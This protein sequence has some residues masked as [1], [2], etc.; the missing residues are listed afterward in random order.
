[1]QKSAGLAEAQRTELA[2]HCNALIQAYEGEDPAAMRAAT[3]DVV[4]IVR[5]SFAAESGQAYEVLSLYIIIVAINNFL[6]NSVLEDAAAQE[7]FLSVCLSRLG[8]VAASIRY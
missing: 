7:V 6:A 3:H 2:G 5:D 4:R 8:K 1:M